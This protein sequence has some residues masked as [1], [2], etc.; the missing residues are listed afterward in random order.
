MQCNAMQCTFHSP[1]HTQ[2]PSSLPPASISHPV[3]PRRGDSSP[4]TIKPRVYCCLRARFRGENWRV[5]RIILTS[6][7]SWSTFAATQEPGREFLGLEPTQHS[8]ASGP[9][10]V[11]LQY[12]RDQRLGPSACARSD[13]NTAEWSEGFAAK[14]WS[15]EVTSPSVGLSVDA[16]AARSR[17]RPVSSDLAFDL[18]PAPATPGPGALALAFSF[19][20]R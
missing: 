1:L 15:R 16:R 14:Q 6:P 19:A 5:P 9:T 10:A 13:P 4:T 11:Q 7:A 2:L 20:V 12:L 3:Q 18:L 8:L 17:T